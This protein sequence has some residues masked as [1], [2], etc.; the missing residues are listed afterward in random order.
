MRVRQ[1]FAI[2]SLLLMI[3]AATA[4]S[5]AALIT[6]N[7]VASSSSCAANACIK[8]TLP[9]NTASATIQITG[10]FTGTFQFETS[11]DNSTWTAITAYPLPSGSG[12]TSATSTGLWQLSTSSV[13]YLRVRASAFT[14]GGSAT[15]TMISGTASFTPP[16][17]SGTIGTVTQGNA[18]ASAWPMYLAGTTS[19]LSGQQAVTG[20]ATALAT[21]T[22]KAIC[23]KALNGNAI[24]VY[25]GPT[26]I[27]TSTGL[28][29][30]AGAF[31]CGTITN[32]NLIYVVAST[33]GASVSWFA[34]N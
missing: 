14:A 8:L 33:T 27:T 1:R 16:T 6:G 34:I 2:V 30:S 10:T 15:V 24:N 22:A 28:E 5:Q 21:N 7:I 26:G 11:P 13:A 32:T 3:W 20:S 4:F 9:L 17:S 19:V 29:L 25:I 12:A 23:V 18:G 31:W